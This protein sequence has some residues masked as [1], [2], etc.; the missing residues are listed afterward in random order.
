[1]SIETLGRL[2]AQTTYGSGSATGGAADL[3]TLFVFGDSL[4]DNGSV[5][6]LSGGMVPRTSLAGV[7]ADGTPVD[8]AGRGIFYD[9]V[10]SN[11]P[12]YADIAADLL[13]LPGN[14]GSFLT[15][16][17]NFALGGGTALGGNA[18][19][20]Q[21]DSFENA[22]AL[23]PVGQSG[24]LLAK[25][26]ASV[27]IGLNDLLAIGQAAITPTGVDFAAIA[28]GVEAVADEIAAQT[29]R[30]ADLGVG[31]VVINTLPP[32][33]LFPASDPLVA[34]LGGTEPL[35]AFSDAFNARLR[36]DA[37]A[38]E[39]TGVDVRIVDFASLG[40]E[41]LDDAATFG[42]QSLDAALSGSG[43]SPDVTLLTPDVPIDRLGFI[44]QVHFTAS[45]HGVFGVFQ[46]MTLDDT[47]VDGTDGADFLRGGR[48]EQ[49]I[50]ADDGA[51]LVLAG[52]GDDLVFGGR[53]A[54][55]LFGGRGGDILFGGIGNDVVKGGSGRDI[56]SGGAGNDVVSGG[57]GG[58]IVSG[59][60]GNDLL[61]GGRGRDLLIDGLG[62]DVAYGGR[63]ADLFVYRDAALLG[64]AGVDRDTF[65][66]GSGFDTLLIVT[67]DPVADQAGYL[68][69]NGIST[70]GTERTAFLTADDLS[71]FDFDNLAD[72]VAIADLFGLV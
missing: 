65:F 44:D 10:F 17:S 56:A 4:S 64:G 40:Q 12:V 42:L 3:N 32:A 54:D 23:L 57:T 58:D 39:A 67:G 48:G 14:T 29:Q 62:S 61:F 16:G 71:A 66:G 9:G 55:A 35:D 25:A 22:I 20:T 11:G 72:Q 36:A 37:A 8:L 19:A 45:L 51:D 49:T 38:L 34:P 50:F 41:I 52:R 13:G 31:T 43:T 63:G 69:D 24:A 7:L 30:L 6:L 46:A 2:I 60:T 28:A 26:G 33:S 53:G 15:G 18:L 47:L 68:D 21:I 1:M 70:Y 59:G 27:F 5:F